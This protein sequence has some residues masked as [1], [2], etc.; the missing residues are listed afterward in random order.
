MTLMAAFAHNCP[1]G[2]ISSLLSRVYTPQLLGDGDQMNMVYHLWSEM[3]LLSG[4]ITEPIWGVN[5]VF[6][7]L[8]FLN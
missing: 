8:D 2:S 1:S 3:W 6:W 4:A 5:L 7:L